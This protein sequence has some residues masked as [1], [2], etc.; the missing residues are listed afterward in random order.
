MSSRNSRIKSRESRKVEEERQRE[1]T[2]RKNLQNKIAQ[3]LEEVPSAWKRRYL[4]LLKNNG[5]N[6][7]ASINRVTDISQLTTR[8]HLLPPNRIYIHMK[9]KKHPSI[10][11]PRVLSITLRDDYSRQ[12]NKRDC[13]NK[14]AMSPTL[15]WY[16]NSPNIARVKPSNM[17]SLTLPNGHME[18]VNIR[19]LIR[20]YKNGYVVAASYQRDAVGD[21]WAELLMD[22]QNMGNIRIPLWLL[23]K[24][25]KQPWPVTAMRR[26]PPHETMYN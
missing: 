7:D 20:I 9:N 21:H 18:C 11:E 25:T 5:F 26:K 3:R 19:T 24:A 16:P 14:R 17:L 8:M 13:M 22:T 23:E 10:P 15:L 1:V 6:P 2:Q 4:S 12:D